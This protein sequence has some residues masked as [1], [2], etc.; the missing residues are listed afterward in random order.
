MIYDA[1]HISYDI[2][3]MRHIHI[4]I[5]IYIYIYLYGIGAVHLLRVS[6]FY[7][8]VFSPNQRTFFMLISKMQSV[9]GGRMYFLSYKNNVPGV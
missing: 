8:F 7:L 5:Y 2:I 9:F 3:M 4:Y 6:I 1:H